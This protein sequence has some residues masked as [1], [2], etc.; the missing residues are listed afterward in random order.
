[1]G[2]K[3]LLPVQERVR[4]RELVA[5][6]LEALRANPATRASLEAGGA[7]TPAAGYVTLADLSGGPPPAG[8]PY[9]DEDIGVLSVPAPPHDS[10]RAILSALGELAAQVDVEPED[11]M[12][13]Q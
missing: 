2:V 10:V 5:R 7:A 1:M 4:N 11:I 9:L 12:R 3:I 8:V 6:I 13:S